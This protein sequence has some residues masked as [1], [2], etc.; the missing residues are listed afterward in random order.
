MSTAP[1]TPAP[2]QPPDPGAL[3]SPELA[4]AL[5]ILEAEM[6][7]RAEDYPAARIPDPDPLA[8]PRP[9]AP[10]L[11]RRYHDDTDSLVRL[12]SI[13]KTIR[14]AHRLNPDLAPLADPAR[15]LP[16]DTLRA[17]RLAEAALAAE[18]HRWPLDA[19]RP[20]DYRFRRAVRDLS[21]VV[22]IRM[23]VLELAS[24]SPTTPPDFPGWDADTHRDA[25]NDTDPPIPLP[26]APPLPTDDPA[27]NFALETRG[28]RTTPPIRWCRFNR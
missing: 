2:L 27:L 10:A 16:S 23:S 12:C 5:A 18:I 25:F 7:R 6:L 15:F 11:A 3:L 8:P 26:S 14:D 28:R 19:R 24:I 13:R 21:R 1:T 20:G 9:D 22:G 17:L 4:R